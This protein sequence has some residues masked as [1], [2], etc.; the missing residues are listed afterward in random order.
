MNPIEL[1][2]QMNILKITTLYGDRINYFKFMDHDTFIDPTMNDIEWEKYFITIDSIR[3]VR[4][5]YLE[6]YLEIDK[7]RTQ[8]KE[9][10]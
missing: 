1:E 4:L 3:K 7:L 2:R 9:N 10:I 8:H 6:I 5:G